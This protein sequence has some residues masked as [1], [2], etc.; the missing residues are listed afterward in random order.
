MVNKDSD[1]SN[2]FFLEKQGVVETATEYIMGLLICSCLQSPHSD[3]TTLE[4]DA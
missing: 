2:V 3:R 4:T 1:V